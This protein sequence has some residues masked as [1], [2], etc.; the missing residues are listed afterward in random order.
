MGNRGEAMKH[1]FVAMIAGLVAMGSACTSDPGPP[2][3]ITT[4][5]PGTLVQGRT[6]VDSGLEWGRVGHNDDWLVRSR[7]GANPV[8]PT[9][10]ETVLTPRN[11]DQL[12]DLG[13]P[14]VLSPTYYAMVPSGMFIPPAVVTRPFLGTDLLLAGGAA[15]AGPNQIFVDDGG[16]WSLG[17]TYAL[18]PAG[19]VAIAFSDSTLVTRIASSSVN[20][21][22]LVHSVTESAGVVTVG[23]AVP[24]ALPSTWSG[25]SVL[26]GELVGSTL[27]VAGSGSGLVAAV[28]T[29]DLSDPSATA[30]TEVW[31]GTDISFRSFDVDV[32]DSTSTVRAAVG[33]GATLGTG[34][35][36]R[37][38]VLSQTG[39]GPWAPTA[40]LSAPYG[41][42]DLTHGSFFGSKVALDD[43]L[44]VAV[45]RM[46]KV[47][48]GSTVG[49]SDVMILGAFRLT[50]GGWQYEASMTPAPDPIPTPE[51]GRSVA[52]LDVAGEVT[53]VEVMGGDE[54]I[55][56][57]SFF[58]E[59]WRF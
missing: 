4:Q 9:A 15:P 10:T 27:V 37:V 1:L 45:A 43:D 36:G 59:S 5:R 56:P 13:A 54:G 21:P 12:T 53:S 8:G 35:A 22:L 14:Q 34:V 19:E 20:T 33:V 16:T 25:F 44:L 3:V 26:Q 41:L 39:S 11:G 46:A 51:T 18:D 29:V 58:G 50:G 23:P 7:T 31:R 49:A 28:G 30:L 48:S 52:D 57:A 47:P 32:D 38:I 17:G 55:P 40:V 6:I 2:P 42:D 24:I